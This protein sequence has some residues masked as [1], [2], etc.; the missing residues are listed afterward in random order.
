VCEPVVANEDIHHITG[1]PSDP[2]LLYA[3]LGWASLPSSSPAGPLGGI[4]RSHDGGRSWEKL[5]QL[6]R[7]Y[8]RATLVPPARPE[9]LV[10]GPAPRVGRGGRIIVSADGGDSWREAGDGIEVP[11]PDMVE[12]FVGAPDGDVWALCSQGRLLR[13]EP[14]VWRWRSA[15][16]DGSGLDA[17]SVVF[18]GR[19]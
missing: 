3:S 6:G 1:D 16:P 18:A 5:D 7:D 9:L 15:L 19:T 10:A 2:D 17:K 12:L 13:A 8:T 11:M 4:A 14:G